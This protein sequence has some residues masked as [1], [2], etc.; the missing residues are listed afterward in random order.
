MNVNFASRFQS[1]TGYQPFPWQERLFRKFLVGEFPETCSLPTGIGKTSIIIIWLLALI[2]RSDLVPRRLVYVVNRRTVV[3][4]T[5]SEIR[6]LRDNLVECPDIEASLRALCA[7][8]HRG[9]QIFPL[10][11]STLR[12]QLADNQ[13]WAID[14]ARPAVICGTVDMIGS[15]LL[16]GGY[17]IGFRRRPLHAGFLG[18]DVLLVHDEA[19]LE[20]AF[21][22]LVESIRN[23]QER[24]SAAL[25]ERNRLHVIELSAT[26]R[27]DG[28]TFHLD[29]SDHRHLVVQQRVHAVKKLRLH[30][31]ENEKNELVDAVVAKALG[32]QESGRAVLIYLR[33]VSDVEKV[34]EE[35]GKRGKELHGKADKWVKAL[36]GTMRGKERDELVQH[37]VFARFLPE[38][39]RP[40]NV[41]PADGTVFLVCTSAGEVGVNISADDLICDLSTFDSMAQRFGRVNRF[42]DR[43]DT[44][45]DVFH[46]GKF[47]TEA[48][49]KAK[50]AKA[51]DREKGAIIVD[52]RRGK[53]LN[54]LQQ[55]QGNASPLA[56]GRLDISQCRQAF[57]PDRNYADPTDI[58]FDF[59]S[60]T[61]ARGALPGRPALQNYLHGI[62]SWE[63]PV[64]EI[65][66]R[67]EVARLSQPILQQN[68][69]TPEEV[70]AAYPVKPHEILK[71]RTDRVLRHLRKLVKR[72]SHASWNV[73]HVDGDGDVTICS[74][75]DL[76]DSYTPERP[77]INL[78]G[79]L[80][81]LPPAA[82]GLQNGL[83]NGAS[84][85]RVDD[86]A[87][88][89]LIG[90]NQP[91]R[92]REFRARDDAARPPEGMRII[93][94]VDTAPDVDEFSPD[95]KKPDAELHDGEEVPSTP[96]WIWAV[97]P[98]SAD[99]DGSRTAHMPITWQHHTDD[100]V[101]NAQ[102]IADRLL[103]GH[104]ELHAAL[105]LAARAHDLGKRRVIWQ[106]SIGNPNPTDWFAKSGKGSGWGRLLELTRYRHEFGS[107]FDL[108]SEEPYR[109]EFEQLSP[110]MQDVVLH[111]VAVHHG[112]GRPHFPA[113]QAFD[114]HRS[115]DQSMQL[116]TEIPRRLA[117][118]QR[119]YG[120][121]GLAWLE[122][123]LR[124]ADAS[125]SAF[126][127]SCNRQQEASV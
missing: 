88:E 46:P 29:D 67:E 51:R 16:F 57:S 110:E 35:L 70:L 75:R 2:E 28:D 69:L 112:F 39:N 72:S 66:W 113:D 33:S 52:E 77:N 42:G 59:W 74:L 9:N 107:L 15:R 26:A 97:R 62:E 82:G 106:R 108:R 79:A 76:V 60:L 4:Q 5:T 125:A 64:T 20:P 127:S 120:R 91:G 25:G 86:V 56:L 85:D 6:K 83:L 41:R 99:D 89:W 104:P 96:I 73:W 87:D 109:S 32:Y 18:Q 68:Q 118:L 22:R 54:L 92:V 49:I 34:E 71:D 90:D 8:D 105:M 48:E 31:I 38:D 30:P 43:S 116:S 101:D 102:R 23:E 119:R 3:D 121:W 27:G 12:G 98:A 1:L 17:R 36:T 81:I 84:A 122:S 13:E 47:S 37:A 111:L 78:D 45:I 24:E 44:T 117:R 21:Q 11:I 53:T 94:V 50:L 95:D 100:V 103:T 93:L 114:P 14:P 7:I 65:A 126:P 115:D 19:H 40:E 61:T 63:P 10:G 58:L 123:L 80:L 55:L 124:A